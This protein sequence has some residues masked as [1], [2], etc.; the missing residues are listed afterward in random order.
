MKILLVDDQA[1]LMDGIAN[2]LSKSAHEVVEKANTVD[3]ALKYFNETEFDILI[4]DYN[5]IDDNG[6][7]LIRKVKDVYPNMKLI[8]LSMHDEIHLVEEI[9]KDQIN[10]HVINLTHET[11]CNI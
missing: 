3:E 8:V 7:V 6:L 1:I 2:L 11:S 5:I 4:A 10:G 9:L